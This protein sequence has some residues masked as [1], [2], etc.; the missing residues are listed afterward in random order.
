[1]AKVSFA[2][3]QQ[4]FL[5]WRDEIDNHAT[6][7]TIDHFTT[8]TSRGHVVK[9]S[10]TGLDYQ[11]G[12]P[13]GGSVTTLDISLGGAKAVSDIVVSD[14][15]ADFYDYANV[16]ALASRTDRTMALW[17]A[18]F[19]DDDQ[20]DFGL[21]TSA[22]NLMIEF[23]GDGYE[24]LPDAFGGR[25]VIRGDIGQGLVMGDYISA[26]ANRTAFGGDDDIQLV[27]SKGAYVSG[28]ILQ[29]AASAHFFAGDDLIRLDRQGTAS[30][31]ALTLF[32]VLSAGDDTLVGSEDGDLL[33]GDVNQARDGSSVVFGRDVI[34]GGDGNDAIHGDFATNRAVNF[35]GGNDKLY[36]DG[37][38][39]TVHGNEG[40]DYLDGGT[41][42]D[43]L[44]GDAGNDTMRGGAG[45]DSITG[46]DGADTV[47]FSDKTA[48]VELRL[49]FSGSGTVKVRGVA[50][51][52]V[53]AVEHLVGGSAGDK[54]LAIAGDYTS[55]RFEGRA[56][57]DTLSTGL[58]RDTLIGGAGSDKLTGGAGADQFVFG[59]KLGSAN[60]DR[61]VD[62]LHG[63]DEIALDDAIF[64]ALGSSFDKGEFVARA[65]GH[66]ATTAAQH[67]VYDKSNGSLWYDADGNGSH[68]AIQFAQFGTASAHPTNL[69]WGDFAIV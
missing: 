25:D 22:R 13:R 1:M 57:N 58:G 26:G 39:D 61:I 49:N 53:D 24:A 8:V 43:V 19:A 12:V 30:G 55:N 28:D 7:K 27:N 33:L 23:G 67:I 46:G 68:A 16:V 60:L 50:E 48:S 35:R 34:H 4:D 17:S 47:D 45:R 29:A 56:G 42:N 38:S 62:F 52:V 32:G 69:T 59:A 44:H 37:G 66:S 15:N 10:G 54:F 63:A 3:L 40:S 36:G 14:I 65:S 6:E 21:G 51:D 5:M 2:N 11:N 18:T 41:G 64:K 31:D 20:I 9:L